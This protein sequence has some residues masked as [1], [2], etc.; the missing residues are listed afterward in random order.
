MP[1]R[2]PSEAHF[3]LTKMG[4]AIFH[5]AFCPRHVPI[6][7]W[8]VW[9]WAFCAR[10]P[11]TF[12]SFKP[13]IYI[14]RDNLKSSA[15]RSWLPQTRTYATVQVA[16]T[17]ATV[18]VHFTLTRLLLCIGD[19]DHCHCAFVSYFLKVSVHQWLTRWTDSHSCY[20]ACWLVCHVRNAE[21][22]FPNVLWWCPSE[23]SMC[24]LWWK[25]S[26]TNIR[27]PVRPTAMSSG[28]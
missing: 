2:N 20:C 17:C 4:P 11:L 25:A 18:T 3:A 1:F 22:S 6:L 14:M 10:N 7:M 26:V 15:F 9:N 23:S 19:L 13:S 21:V 16:V 12:C 24:I 28:T 5:K 8:N 27:S